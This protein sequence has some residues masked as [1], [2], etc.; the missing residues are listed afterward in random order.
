MSIERGVGVRESD[1]PWVDIAVRPGY[2]QRY[3]G[4]FDST[5]NLGL[6]IGS[7]YADPY[8][9]SPS[10]RHTFQQ[11]RYVVQGKMKYGAQVYGVGDCLYLPEGA[12][13]GPVKPVPVNEG[14]SDQMHFVDMQFMGPSGIPYPEPEPVV[15]AQRALAK[16]GKFEEGVYTYANG[17]KRDAYEA[18]LEKLTGKPV[19]Y[20]PSRLNSYVVMKS[21]AYS[22]LPTRL[23]GVAQ[24]HL[25]YFFECG[26]NVKL[27]TLKAGA[28][29]PASTP[30]GHRAMLLVSGEI[31]LDGESF[32]AFSYSC[33]RRRCLTARCARRPTASCS[34]SAGRSPVASCRSSCSDRDAAMRLGMVVAPG[35]AAPRVVA[36]VAGGAVLDLARIARVPSVAER[37]SLPADLLARLASCADGAWLALDTQPLIAQLIAAHATL[38]DAAAYA[39]RLEDVTLAPPITQP[40]KYIAAGR[41]YASHLK[42]SQAIWAARGKTI[43]RAPHPT[44]FV[45]FASA[46]TAS[47]TAI[48]IPPGVDS[49]DYEIELVIVIGRRAAHNVDG[50]SALNYVAGYTIGNDVGAR[51]LQR[52]EMEH[53]IGL[54]LSKNFPTFAPLGPWIVTA[55]EIPDPQALE[56]ELT[57]DGEVRQQANTDSMIFGVA[58]LVSYWS[59][60]G[61]APG[62]MITT[63]TPS[64]VAIARPDPEPYYLK[65][66]NVVVATIERIGE[67]LNTVTG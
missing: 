49:V 34:R 40:A 17:R 8:Y 60:V 32:P 42:E 3:K 53:Q 6:R 43:E 52:Y 61:L 26:P 1:L 47:G 11:V 59:Q 64:G 15:E 48:R 16:E 19:V 46:I 65:P 55:D 51:K 54:T 67:L 62:D 21:D 28:A 23:A 7:L 36:F 57:V 13:Y 29:L 50:A 24:K 33:F 22:E 63:G 10:H 2:K 44:A 39:W 4:F 18:I 66:G 45:K 37:L 12:Y 27:Y 41:N 9:H 56:L 30:D 31:E 20:P 38:S 35:A 5:K 25:G 58:E 14:G